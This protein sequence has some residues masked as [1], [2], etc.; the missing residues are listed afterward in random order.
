MA[1]SGLLLPS[2]DELGLDLLRVPA[3]RRALS[4]ATPFVLVAT[5]FFFADRGYWPLALACPVLLSFLTYGSTSHDLVHCN[6]RL[7]R[8]FNEVMLCATELIAFRSGHAYRASHLHHHAHFPREDDLEGAGARM[9]FWQAGLDG[10]T[11]QF[12]LWR[13]ALRRRDAARGWI[14]AE[15]VAV[16]FL[17]LAAAALIPWNPWPAVYAGLM[18]AGSCVFPIVTAYIPHDA[19]GINEL[20]QTRLFRGRVLSIL[21]LEHLYHLEHHLFPQ[22]PHHNWPKLAHR[23]DPHFQRLGLRATRLFF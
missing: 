20:T 17:L 23:L 19:S 22:V 21:A 13:C 5:F 16:A 4:L 8:W 1:S 6:L 2:L 18:I 11:L 12:R 10:M 9:S 15:G 7:P 3:W 14:V